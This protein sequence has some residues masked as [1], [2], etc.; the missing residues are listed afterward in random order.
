MRNAS[1]GAAG[2][3]RNGRRHCVMFAANPLF[4]PSHHS[5]CRWGAWQNVL[6]LRLG[7]FD[8]LHLA[9]W[10]PYLY[11]KTSGPGAL[12]NCSACAASRVDPPPR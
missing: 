1:C 7:S 2:V 11:P 10:R 8:D 6:P 4:G 9:G 3:L 5:S 12:A